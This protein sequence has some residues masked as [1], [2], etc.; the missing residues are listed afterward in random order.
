MEEDPV[1][2]GA[3]TVAIVSCDILGHSITH[4]TEQIRR[5]A[6]INDIVAA[7]IREMPPEQVVWSSGGD[8]GHVVLRGPRR[9]ENALR[10]AWALLTWARSERVKLRITGHVGHVSSVWGADGRVQ[11]VGSAINFAGWLLRQLHHEAVV[12]SDAFRRAVNPAQ[13]ELEIRFHDERL[14]LDRNLK[15]Q[16]LYLMTISGVETAWLDNTLDDHAELTRR[17][18]TRDRPSGWDVVYFAKRIWQVNSTDKHAKS[19]LASIA[20]TL[21]S[22][23]G[24][25]QGF[26]AS[27]GHY[28]LAEFVKFGQLI[29]RRPGEVICRYGDPGESMFVILHGDVGIYNIENKGFGGRA[30][31]QHQH[32]R[33]EV[34]GELASVLN[35]D[36]TADLV[37]LTNVALLAF[38]YEEVKKK[39][40][41]TAT[42]EFDRFVVERVLEHVTQAA[43]YL[44]GSHRAGPLS[45]A[46]K[47][48]QLHLGL[49]DAWR[50]AL[51][52]LGEHS[53]LITIEPGPLDL[54]FEHVAPAS[55]DR[56]GLY[57]LVS[58]SVRSP[59]AAEP[60][61]HGAQCPALF[62]DLPNLLMKPRTSYRRTAEPIKILRIGAAGIDRLELSQRV[63]L[64]NALAD[65]AGTVPDE[66]E[67]HV[68][69]CHSSR[70][71]QVVRHIRDRLDAQGIRCWFD[72]ADLPVGASA[73]AR[74]E[75]GLLS[76]RYLLVCA[77]DN[78]PSASWANQEIDA[79]LQFDVEDHA[80][81]RILVL[82]LNYDSAQT[83]IPLLLRGKVW[84][85]Y[86]RPG[87]FE[88]LVEVLKE[89]SARPSSAEAG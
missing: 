76:S 4:E 33:G 56:S 16:L 58:G 51:L 21:T 84:L 38:N 23:T 61:L 17:L 83:S 18:S 48:D 10:L 59:D 71:K 43:S 53:Q 60:D 29:E 87:D 7:A 86:Q 73:R 75:R 34:V 63:Q 22:A 54:E 27:M 41:A 24:D 67:Y 3:E 70:D 77:S 78:L 9:L 79:V 85:E 26:L 49:E 19:A 30:K 65:A 8:G 14:F 69:L 44:A 37:A 55:G 64:Q 2:S 46:T 47:S 20:G 68:Y 72:E 74:M 36:R 28:E 50:A 32:G 57:I 80:K 31:P 40:P 15:P 6:A 62:T 88:A 82:K 66:Y 81:P 35:R 5:V 89:P 25:R 13:S 12:V 39:L 11:V 42:T 45:A 1:P 52:V